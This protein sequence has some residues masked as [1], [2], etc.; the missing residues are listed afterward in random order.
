MKVAHVTLGITAVAMILACAGGGANSAPG[1]S[2]PQA[3]VVSPPAA[4]EPPP[5]PVA[6]PPPAITIPAAQQAFCDAVK[7]GLDG[8][9]GAQGGGANQLIL[10]KLRTVRKAAVTKAVKGATFKDWVGDL[11]DLT[12]TGDGKAAVKV[13]LMCDVAVTIGT[14]N[15]AMSD[16]MDNSLIDQSNPLYDGLAQLGDGAKVK[17]SGKFAIGDVDGFRESSL[18][19]MGSM[20]DPAYIVRLMGISGPL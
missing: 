14:W 6:P 3:P 15:N 12:T 18:T 13:T 19:E 1:V 11:T 8:Y 5:A 9:K 2:A 7:A 17:V 10:S 4:S 20:T 16:I